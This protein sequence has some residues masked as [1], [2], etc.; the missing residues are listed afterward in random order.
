MTLLRLGLPSILP[1]LLIHLTAMLASA[2]PAA[3]DVAP[4][5]APE[6]REWID[7]DT[8]HRIHRLTD[9]PTST[10]FYFNMNAYPPDGTRMV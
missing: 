5:T 10:G 9:E 7:P 3:P 1:A 8:G 2:Q 6:P 4:T